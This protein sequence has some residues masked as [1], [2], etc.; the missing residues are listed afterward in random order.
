[1][2]AHTAGVTTAPC[3][4]IDLQ[5]INGCHLSITWLG[6]GADNDWGHVGAQCALPCVVYGASTT[7][8]VGTALQ[9]T[10]VF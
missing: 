5:P 6:D 9:A 2:L 4:G 10:N 7:R 1:M 3:R 8:W